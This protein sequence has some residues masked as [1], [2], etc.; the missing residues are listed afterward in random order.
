M[1]ARGTGYFRGCAPLI[2]SVEKLAEITRRTRTEDKRGTSRE[3]RSRLTKFELGSAGA[4]RMDEKRETLR[5]K[6]WKSI[7]MII[8]LGGLVLSSVVGMPLWR[9]WEIP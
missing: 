6:N 2:F 5:R 1:L 7:M 4:P 3:M 9:R 8:Q